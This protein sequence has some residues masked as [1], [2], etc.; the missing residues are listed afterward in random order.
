MLIDDNR[1]LN[2]L[3]AFDM[4]TRVWSPLP[5][6]SQLTHS[7]PSASLA[8]V[9]SR[10]YTLVAG[11]AQVMD[12]IMQTDYHKTK[13]GLSPIAAMS[14]WTPLGQ[15]PS[16]AGPGERVGSALEVVTTGQGRNY[17]LLVGGESA[18]ENRGDIWTLQ[19][20]PEGSTAASVKDAA[21]KA[22][23]KGT[24]EKDW[25]EVKYFDSE[26]VMVQEGQAGRGIGQRRRFA[27]SRDTDED[28]GT[29]FVHGGAENGQI[30]GDGILMTVSI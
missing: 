9:G 21:R 18:A 4:S 26:G 24:G 1:P 22:I 30:A 10:L 2:D 16:S 8:I 25:A 13:D 6:P 19:L 17:L 7:S 5:S 15:A 11:H 3:W 29:V 23:G 27:W 28:G 14:P 12:L 20:Q